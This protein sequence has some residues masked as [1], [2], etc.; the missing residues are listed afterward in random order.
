MPDPFAVAVAGVAGSGKSTLGRALAMRLQA[1]LLDLDT[2]T[3]PLLDALGTGVF[4]GHWLASE[5]A[6]LVR[7]G[8][9]A[10]LLATA[11]EVLASAGGVVLVAPFTQELTGGAAWRALQGA[12]GPAALRMVQIVG[13]PDLFAARRAGRGSVRDQ[14]RP[15][16]GE[17]VAAGVPV[18][19][20]DAELPTDAQLE[21]VL[22]D[23]GLA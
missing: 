21:Q 1:P 4:G 12:V 18:L 7:Q 8:R 23:L 9:Y 13:S 11:G 6:A 2:L 19:A 14:H 5:H 15:A 16:G 22:A 10:A 3:N 20:V 17:V